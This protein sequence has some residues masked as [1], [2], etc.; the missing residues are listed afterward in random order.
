MQV[1]CSNV[2]GGA[3]RHTFL[4]TRAL[5]LRGHACWLVVPGDGSRDVYTPL[6]DLGVRVLRMDFRT[7]PLSSLRRLR[8]IVRR[9]KINV[10]HSHM[11][12]ADFAVWLATLGLRK[13][14]RISTLHHSTKDAR[15]LPWRKLQQRLCSMIALKNFHKVFAVS[16]SIRVESISYF[17]LR[18]ESTV[19]VMNSIDFSEMTV[20][21]QNRERLLDEFDIREDDFVMACSGV[22]HELK[23]QITVIQALA[24]MFSRGK[25]AKLFLLGDGPERF[26][27]EAESLRLGVQNSVF[28]TGYQER[29]NEW[30]SRMNLFIQPS[31]SE[32]LSR[33]ILEAM[34]FSVPV[35]ASDIPSSREVVENGTTGLLFKPGHYEEL[36]DAIEKICANANL[37]ANLG[38]AGK[39]FVLRNCSMEKMVDSVLSHLPFPSN[40]PPSSF[41][42]LLY[43][44]SSTT[45]AK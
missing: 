45:D 7:S 25:K 24:V 44:S 12:L 5:I 9:E 19:T 10:I 29:M 32:A 30:Y 33:S 13:H 41:E 11:Y 27:F 40:H 37:A 31:R 38:K 1:I 35:V 4:F 34:Y 20:D 22:Y 3:E 16:E 15:L 42:S 14:L 26:R 21:T 17:R 2:I 36:A 18:P 23:S 8:K 28:L 39:E 6:E 43:E